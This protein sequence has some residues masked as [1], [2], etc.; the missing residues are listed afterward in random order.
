MTN[1]VSQSNGE[2]LC[3]I[4]STIGEKLYLSKKMVDFHFI[5]ETSDGEY[6]RVPAHRN[7]L[8]ASSDVFE[9]MERG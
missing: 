1:S 8:I 6:E 4:C 2:F 7:F 3:Q 5:F 9:V